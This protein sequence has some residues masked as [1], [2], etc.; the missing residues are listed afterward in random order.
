MGGAGAGKGAAWEGTGEDAVGKEMFCS[1]V[2]AGVTRADTLVR[3][4]T[5]P[6]KCV[7]C[8]VCILHLSEA[9]F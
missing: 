1:S 8:S 9:D 7:P 5:V 6:L 4:Q 2:G 3:T